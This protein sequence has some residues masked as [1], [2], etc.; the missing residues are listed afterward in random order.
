M[1]S[2][3]CEFAF[4]ELRKS[5]DPAA[6]SFLHGLLDEVIRIEDQFVEGSQSDSVQGGD[7]CWSPD[8]WTKVTIHS[9][10]NGKGVLQD[11]FYDRET[12]IHKAARAALASK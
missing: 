9:F 3:F 2:K 11:Y 4:Q 7:H 5:E 8:H 10:P 1:E 6:K 12:P